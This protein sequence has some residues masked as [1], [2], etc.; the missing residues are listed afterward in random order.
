MPRI[1]ALCLSMFLLT[2]AVGSSAPSVAATASRADEIRRI[3]K[4]LNELQTLQAAFIQNNPDGSTAR[5]KIYL[6]RPGKARFEYEP[7]VPLLLVSNGKWLIHVDKELQQVSNY[8]LEET[9]AYLLLR[10]DIRFGSDLRV[11]DF[12]QGEK[13]MRIRLED[14]RNPDVGSVTLTFADH[15]LELRSWVVTDAQGLETE[16]ALVNTRTGMELDGN[17]FDYLEQF[18]RSAD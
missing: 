9:P 8:P 10:E 5:G 18:N 13:V 14:A 1:V 12:W 17:L 4:Y 3:E 15:P 2:V 16:L 11:K 7:P 6:K